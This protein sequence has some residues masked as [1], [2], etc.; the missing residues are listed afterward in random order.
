LVQSEEERK[1]KKKEYGQRPEVKARRKITLE[2]YNKKP[3]NKAKKK[4]YEQSSQRKL[5]RKKSYDKP[6]NKAKRKEVRDRPENK[7]KKKEYGQRPENKA[8]D[9][10]YRGRPEVKARR[11]AY[12]KVFRSKSENKA[13]AQARRD[14]PENKAKAKNDRDT[15]RLKVLQYYSKLHSNS[16]IP[17]CRCC[18]LNEHIDFLSLDHIAGKH[19]M[20]SEPELIKLG[21]NS[22]WNTHVLSRWIVDKNYLLDL[23][24]DYFQILCHNC[25]F[26]KGLT[27]NNNKCSHETA[28]LEKTFDSM[29]AQSSFEL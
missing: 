16:D 22:E 9:K 8:K 29:T 28:R 26:T 27:K 14:K 15:S 5:M 17:C 18:G 25:N 11:E 2:K 23:K 24:K 19:E 7:A 13:K 3:E 12:S 1:A 6:E 20:N 21:Y 10:E 4:A